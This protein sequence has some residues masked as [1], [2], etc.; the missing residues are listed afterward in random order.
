MSD[1]SAQPIAEPIKSDAKPARKPGKRTPQGTSFKALSARTSFSVTDLARARLRK[2]GVLSDERLSDECKV[3]RGL[4]RG[5]FY[6]LRKVDANVRKAK[7]AHN[8]R[9]PWPNNMGQSAF[10]VAVLGEKVK[11]K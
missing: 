11:A 8:D 10:K 9:R 7:T 4:L 5:Q 2:R 1:Q 6:D 3:V